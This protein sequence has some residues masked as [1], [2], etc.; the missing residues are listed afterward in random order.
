[1][2]YH[3]EIERYAAISCLLAVAN[4]AMKKNDKFLINIKSYASRK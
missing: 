3:N 2:N 4:K 1:M